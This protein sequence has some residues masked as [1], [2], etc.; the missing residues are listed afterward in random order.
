MRGL[1]VL[2][3]A[4]VAIELH[5]RGQDAPGDFAAQLDAARRDPGQA[6]FARLRLAFTKTPGY[7]PDLS[8]K[9][10]PA[11]VEQELRNGERAAA[12]VALDRSLDGHWIDPVAQQYAAE[13]CRRIDEPGRAAMH[14]AFAAGLAEAIL[15]SGDGRAFETAWAVLGQDEEEF[16]LATRDLHGGERSVVQR[17]GHWY[18]VV[19]FRDPESGR[20]LTVYFNIDL[21]HRWRAKRHQA[22]RA[23][24]ARESVGSDQSGGTP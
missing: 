8:S 6:D 9:F 13:I 1:A 22:E 15:R 12:M 4:L 7:Q 24:A 19:R 17:D 16:I 23:Q 14:Q 20:D 2:L 18:D 3:V 5:A 21:P 11:P 10:D